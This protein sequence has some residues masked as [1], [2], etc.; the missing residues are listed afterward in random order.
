MKHFALLLALILTPLTVLPGTAEAKP[1]GTFGDW[2]AYVENEGGQ[3]LC[4]MLS[5]PKKSEGKYTK[6]GDPYFLVSHRPAENRKNEISIIAGYGYKPGSDA[7]LTVDAKTTFKLFTDGDSA[8]ARDSKGDSAI[9]NAMR[10]GNKMVV[11][12]SSA[13]GT[14]TTDTYSLT[15]VSAAFKAINKACGL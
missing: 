15:G 10:R 12:G 8:W 5:E 14:L 6:R 3:I 9:A 13:R 7:T 1:L 4:F 2:T 11:K